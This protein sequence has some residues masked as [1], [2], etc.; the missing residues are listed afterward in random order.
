M[1]AGADRALL[2]RVEVEL[3]NEKTTPQALDQPA[4]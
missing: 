2:R 1:Q 4:D 3:G